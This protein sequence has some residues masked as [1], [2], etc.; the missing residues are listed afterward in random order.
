M[1]YAKVREV[2]SLS[3]G[4]ARSAGIDFYIPAPTTKFISRLTELNDDK[5]IL[6]KTGFI[7]KPHSHVLIPSG[8]CMNLR[9]SGTFL[10]D[11]TNALALIAHNK[12]SIG[13]MQLDVAATV[14]DEDYKGEI[15]LS[16]TNTSDR[17]AK[18]DF[19]QKAVQFI[20]V[21]VI[22]EDFSEES[23]DTLFEG[24]LSDRVSGFGSTGKM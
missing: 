19:E 13:I 18:L 4:T 20:L 1:K 12:S 15:H 14:I 8:I 9:S 7:I 22:I 5:I 24:V 3:R 11:E 17:P 2:K 16:L 21:P 23:I 10:Y 6:S